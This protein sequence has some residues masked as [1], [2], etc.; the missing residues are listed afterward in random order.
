[1]AMACKG[2]E[3]LDFGESSPIP[4]CGFLG[5]VYKGSWGYL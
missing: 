3:V 5:G 1:M 2:A 4:P